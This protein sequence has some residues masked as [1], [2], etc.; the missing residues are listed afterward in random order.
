L[1]HNWEKRIKSRIRDEEVAQ[2][3]EYLPSKCKALS[4]NAILPKNQAEPVFIN[5]SVPLGLKLPRKKKNRLF[6]R[7]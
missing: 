2:E 4:S 6:F 7:C 5:P 1:L 3:A